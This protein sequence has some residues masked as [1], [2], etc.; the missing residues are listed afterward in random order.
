MPDNTYIQWL[1]QNTIR[2]GGPG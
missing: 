2:D 1:M